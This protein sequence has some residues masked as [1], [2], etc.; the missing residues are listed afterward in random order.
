M[1]NPVL[2]GTMLTILDIVFFGATVYTS[3][4]KCE[5]ISHFSGFLTVATLI[6]TFIFIGCLNI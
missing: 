4:K 6:I 3:I 1:S 5:D 2:I